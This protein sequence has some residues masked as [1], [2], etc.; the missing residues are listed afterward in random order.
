MDIAPLAPGSAWIAEIA[1]RQFAHWGPLTGFGSAAAYR[2]FLAGAAAGR[3]LPKVIAASEASRLLGSVNLLASE[4]T[5]RPALTPWIGQLFVDAAARSRGIGEALVRSA[6]DRA[7]LLG[8]RHL[9]LFTSGTLPAYYRARGWRNVEEVD[10]LDRP[11][12]IMR[13]DLG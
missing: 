4:M 8:F 11:R 6:A 12:T 3:G 10:Y 7:A 5:I 1:E 9:H 2:D 13:L